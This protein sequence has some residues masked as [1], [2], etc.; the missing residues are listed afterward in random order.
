MQR[1]ILAF[2]GLVGA[3]S[4]GGDAAARHL[5]AFDPTR[6]DLASTAARYGL[7]HAL[8]LLALA[9]LWNQTQ[10]GAA[11]ISLA[12]S[13]WCF[14]GAILLFCGSLGLMAAGFPSDLVRAVPVGG[15]LFILGWA[16][17]FIGAVAFVSKAPP[18]P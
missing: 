2:T 9:A 13:A 10:R 8:A 7:I 3:L 15:S 12:V 5:L 17:L 14:I 11:R 4:V 16:A 6:V 1:L 18:A